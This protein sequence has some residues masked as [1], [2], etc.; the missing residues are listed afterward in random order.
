MPRGRRHDTMSSVPRAPL[1]MPS[2]CP[3]LRR[4]GLISAN[5]RV[6]IGPMIEVKHGDQ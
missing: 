3:I 2:E 4:F 5:A 6:L 1:N